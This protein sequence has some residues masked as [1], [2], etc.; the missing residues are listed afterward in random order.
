MDNKNQHKLNSDP[1][2]GST[3]SGGYVPDKTAWVR[4]I[5]RT[6]GI[7]YTAMLLAYIAF[8]L[9]DAF[10]IPQD[11][12]SADA[13]IS[14]QVPSSDGAEQGSSQAQASDDAEQNSDQAQASDDA[15]QDSVQAQASGTQETEIPAAPVVT[16]TSYQD[17]KISIEIT[18][19][20]LLDTTVYVADVTLRDPSCL[21]TAL[22]QNSFGRNITDTTSSIA[23]QNNAILAI[24][25]DYYG[26]RSTGYV[27]RHGYIYRYVP[28]DDPSQEDLVIYED[29]SLGIIR[30]SE[31]PAQSLED[32][33]VTD[34]LS[35][36][37]G[38][39][40]D[41]EISVNQDD[42]VDRAQVTNPRTAIG[43]I[44]PLHYL[45]VVSD[46]RT[47]K[48]RGLSL[49]EL[50]GFMKE[51][52]CSF[53]YNLDGGGSSTMCFMGKVL[54]NPTTFGDEIAERGVSDII[55]IGRD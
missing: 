43:V 23:A 8:T 5:R 37:P 27:M 6:W 42:E 39:V 32:T 45:F 26:F 17:D 2:P 21:R 14:E 51:Q 4:R 25:G 22:A 28:V 36:G 40:I 18:T 47:K 52:G 12:V 29:G 3:A 19:T 46:G 33:D 31:V 55:Y 9:L 53:A 1:A 15:G 38:L 13:V 49:Y 35:F 44:E 7:V 20:R 16:D 54:N 48:S 10:V 30:E 11:I 41:G 24:N 50:A 34:I